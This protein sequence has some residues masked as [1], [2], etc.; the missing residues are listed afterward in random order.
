MNS[1][2]DIRAKFKRLKDIL[3]V[4]A[5]EDD[6]KDLPGGRLNINQ[7]EEAAADGLDI[8]EELY[9]EFYYEKII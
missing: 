7:Y 1:T 2:E 3:A 8:L 6:W 9:Q 4:Y 5:K